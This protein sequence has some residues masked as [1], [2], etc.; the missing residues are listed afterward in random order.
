MTD[1]S[2]TA[3]NGQDPRLQGMP[4]ATATPGDTEHY[5]VFPFNCNF[6]GIDLY[7]WDSNPGDHITFETE[8]YAGETYGWIRYK[9]FG[10]TWNVFP[11]EKTRI[12]LFPTEPFL[13]NRIKCT[14]KNL[15]VSDVK[16]A[17]NLFQFVDSKIVRPSY[18]EEGE[19]W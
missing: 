8:Y 11:H 5:Y 16:F 2:F 1:T 6:E 3:K 7:A 17:I 13:G 9:K 19:D 4:L 14:Y 10:K 12:I 15:G 18:L